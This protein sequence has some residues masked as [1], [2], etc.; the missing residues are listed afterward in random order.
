[1]SVAK[2]Q[3]IEVEIIDLG[4][5]GEGIGRLDG[6][7]FFIEGGLP[8][9]LVEAV[10]T[11]VKKNYA[12]AKLIKVKRPSEGRVEAACP[13]FKQCGGCQIMSLDYETSQLPFK[14][15]VVQDA[16]ARIGGFKDVAVAPI[17]GMASPNRYRNK[18]QYPVAMQG[19]LAQIGFYKKASHQVVDVK[20]CL[21][22]ADNHGTITQ[23]IR[24][25]VI[26][27]KIPVYDEAVGK[28]ILRHV[29]IRNAK[30]GGT[31]IVL[32]VNANGLHYENIL[33]ERLVEAVSGIQSIVINTNKSKGNRVLGFENRVIY[34]SETIVDH[35]NDL[36]FEI[37]PLSFFQVNPVQTEVLYG[38]ALEFASL[39]GSETV[40]DIYCGI[41]TISLFLAKAAKK[42]IGVELIE[43]AI[44]DARANATRN[45]FENCEFQVGKAEEVL[46]KLYE[47]GQQADV[48]VVDPPRK[49]CEPEVLEAMLK[50]APQRIVYVSC[51]PSTMARDLKIL[52]AEGGYEITNVQPVD[53]FPH[54]THVECVIGL[55][56]KESL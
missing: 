24:D 45:G 36:V 16:L 42:V 49:G 19:P 50:M 32:V 34:G 33:K 7:T 9:D 40:V 15:K 4:D 21:L 28:G 14:Q 26:E 20:D 56:R 48:V 41:G 23:I 5:A 25:F 22:Q 54:T 30:D 17:I 46:P 43:S 39:T 35:I 29:M 38:K 37:S 10:V 53:M 18:G 31:M 52:C 3:K 55:R 8:G 27:Y 12:V 47:E 1:M 11:Q 13:V 2:D 6:L 44:V 51:K